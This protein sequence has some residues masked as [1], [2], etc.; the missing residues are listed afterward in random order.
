MEKMD[1]HPAYLQPDAYEPLILP[2]GNL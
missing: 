1:Y 2:D